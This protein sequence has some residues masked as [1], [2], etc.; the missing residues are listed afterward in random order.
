MEMLFR[1]LP[2]LCD[3]S[4]FEFG[5]EERGVTDGGTYVDAER[6]LELFFRQSLRVDSIV[7][8][9]IWRLVLRLD[10][11]RWCTRT[12]ERQV[13]HVLMADVERDIGA[14]AFAIR[15]F[16]ILSAGLPTCPLRS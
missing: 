11:Q 14:A 12:L 2:D 13:L 1:Y 4:V 7:N 8:L 3:G 15:L 5:N 10:K 9:D 16:N 6:H